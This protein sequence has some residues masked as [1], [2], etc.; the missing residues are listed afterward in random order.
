MAKLTTAV[1]K[2]DGE[3][4]LKVYGVEYPMRWNARVY[5]KFKTETGV[6]P[7]ALFMDM[8]NEVNIVK[9]LGTFEKEADLANT[10]LMA[11]LSG[12]AQMH[13][14][15]WLFY[16]AAN[17]MDK[18]VSF[19]EMQEAVLL[20]GVMSHKYMPD[21]ELVTTYPYLVFEFAIFA[22]NIGEQPE[23][24]KKKKQSLRPSFTEKLRS[25]FST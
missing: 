19:E 5:A 6:D 15:A 22:L 1:N 2:Y 8:I 7:H 16:L 21:G 13:L 3:I 9:S 4:K 17:E 12:I 20:E 25:L 18:A 10:E 11:R 23:D 24:V 14:A